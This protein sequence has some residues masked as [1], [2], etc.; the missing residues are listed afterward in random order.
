[1][2]VIPSPTKVSFQNP[3]QDSN[4]RV[5][6]RAR[7]LCEKEV[8]EDCMECVSYSADEHEVVLGKDRRFTFDR[9]F[10]PGANQGDIYHF[11]VKP[12]VDSCLFGYNATIIAYGQ[13]GSGKTYTMG[14]ANSDED[15]G[16]LP[17]AICQ[18]YENIDNQRKHSNFDVKCSFVEIYNEEI[19]DLLHPETPSKSIFI[20]EDT[21]GDII[22]AGVME[23]RVSTFDGMM[24]ALGDERKHGQHVPYRQSKLTRIL[25]ASKALVKKLQEESFKLSSKNN[26]C[27]VR[28][29]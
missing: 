23:E 1:M 26:Q 8:V 15:I 29:T 9:V 28:R 13:T 16:I 19:K 21:N 22:L 3:F 17:H 18:L 20:R 5:F 6:V 11:F 10:I 14:S 7:P 12:L 2:E 27:M 4:V 24:S 25:Q